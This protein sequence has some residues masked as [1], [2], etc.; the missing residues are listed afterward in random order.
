MA[1]N[2]DIMSGVFCMEFQNFKGKLPKNWRAV[3]NRD[4]SKEALLP[5]TTDIVE[6]GCIEPVHVVA[7]RD[8]L[9]VIT[10]Y[11]RIQSLIYLT[12]ANPKKRYYIKVVLVGQ[13]EFKAN[14]KY[15]IMRLT[16][17]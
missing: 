1:M 17:N 3:S 4:F 10:G 12:E 14:N 7:Y 16:I 15:A 11:R 13:K 5:L 8:K 9:K 2:L 6:R